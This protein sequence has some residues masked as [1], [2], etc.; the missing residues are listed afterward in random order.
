[1]RC[2]QINTEG[3]VVDMVPQ[4]PTLAE[5]YGVIPSPAEVSGPLGQL[6]ALSAEQG[7]LI[8]LAVAAVW[9]V[10]WGVRQYARV[11]TSR[12]D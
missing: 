12:N 4:P 9:A 10:G 3:Q 1:M 5:C 8:A 11:S 7:G 2:V 6:F